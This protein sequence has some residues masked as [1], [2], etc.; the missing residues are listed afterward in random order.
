MALYNELPVYPVGYFAF[1][2]IKLKLAVIQRGEPG[3]V[4]EQLDLCCI[5][6][7]VFKGMEEGI[8]FWGLG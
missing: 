4:V 5:C 3:E 1:K 6:F 7:G 8:S 2:A